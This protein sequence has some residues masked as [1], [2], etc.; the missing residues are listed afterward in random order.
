MR[1]EV[2]GLHFGYR[3][4]LMIL[5]D[6]S[7]EFAPGAMTGITGESGR[8]KSTLLYLIGLMLTPDAGAIRLDRRE[9]TGLR[10]EER[11]RIRAEHLGFVFQD[12]ILD[13]ARTTLENILEG[14]IYSSH[15]DAALRQT[16]VRWAERLGVSHR[17]DGRP[18]EVSGGQAQRIALAR[19]LVKSPPVVLADEPTG[20]LDPHSASV[21]LQALSEHARDGATVLIASHD[22]GV[23]R[24]C[25]AHLDLNS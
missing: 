2:A 4:D 8:G 23:I 18:G 15:S 7:H 20:N 17:L 1:V 24:A 25:D 22:P 11:S 10:D 16:A 3:S 12:A 6:F 5:K 14:G 19:A 9:V 21:V 13:P